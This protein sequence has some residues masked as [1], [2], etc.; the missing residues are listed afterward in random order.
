MAHSKA[1]LFIDESNASHIIA[2]YGRA[3]SHIVRVNITILLAETGPLYHHE[4]RRTFGLSNSTISHHLAILK[5]HGIILADVQ[6]R[7]IEYNFNT[8]HLPA[9]RDYFTGF[10]NGLTDCVMRN[11][12]D[13]AK[14]AELT[15]FG[16]L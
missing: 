1:H 16:E 15:G 6:G 2:G 12:S 3:F 9:M 8:A 10:L 13:Q 11:S 14:H 4:I 7:F 5:W